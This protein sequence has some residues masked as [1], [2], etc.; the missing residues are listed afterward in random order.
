MASG[1]LNFETGV[2]LGF[3]TRKRLESS[4]ADFLISPW[5]GQAGFAGV[6][7]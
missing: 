3:N 1:S 4:V 5:H 2:P 6:R 7:V